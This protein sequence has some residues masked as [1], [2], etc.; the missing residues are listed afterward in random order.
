MFQ[1]LA[2]ILKETEPRPSFSQL[3]HDHLSHLSKE[4]EHYFPT[5]KDPWPGKEWI[6]DPLVNKPGE[7]TLSVLEEEQ[8]LE[9]ANDG[10]LKSMFETTSNLHTFWIK[11]KAEYPEIATKALK[12][13]FSFPTSYP[14][15]AGFS[16][17]TETKTRLWS[18]LDISNTLWVSL[19]PITPR[20]NHLVAGKQ[21]QGSTDSALWWVV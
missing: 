20:W 6:R 7:S 17:V 8:L 13:L 15:E 18:R 19:S 21:L 16:V 10:D 12:N 2:E 3:V 14:C 1:T 4:F 5:T 9:I 11:V